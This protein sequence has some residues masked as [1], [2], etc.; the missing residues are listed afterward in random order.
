M[1]WEI[2]PTCCIDKTI[3]GGMYVIETITNYKN[4]KS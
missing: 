1:E 2:I 4:G 3:L